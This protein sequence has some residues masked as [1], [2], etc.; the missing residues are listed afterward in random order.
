MDYK[1][2]DSVKSKWKWNQKSAAAFGKGVTSGDE[3][4]W[5]NIYSKLRSAFKSQDPKRDGPE[6]EDERQPKLR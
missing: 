1:N 2:D 6:Q 3:N 4:Q 5:G